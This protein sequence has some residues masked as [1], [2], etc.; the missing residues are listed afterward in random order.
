M[1]EQKTTNLNISDINFRTPEIDFE[2]LEPEMK[3]DPSTD[4]FDKSFDCRDG[5]H[6]DFALN[7]NEH[8]VQLAEG[9]ADPTVSIESKVNICVKT[10]NF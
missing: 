5:S 4:S 9:W 3:V 1:E 6:K 10:F 2:D 7:L 8:L